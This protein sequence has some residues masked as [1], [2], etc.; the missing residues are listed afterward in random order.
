MHDVD[1][2]RR[3]LGLSSPWTVARVDLDKKEQKVDVWLEHEE[4]AHWSCPECGKR[5]SI[6]DHSEEREWRHLDTMQFQTWV[7]AK[8]PRVEC[9]DHGVK[10][11]EPTWAEP[12]SRY[13]SDFERFAIDVIQETDTRG[14]GKILKLAWDAV[15]GIEKRAVARGLLARPPLV[16]KRMGVDEKAVGHGQQYMTLVYNL[17]TSTVEWVGEGRKKDTL[18]AF[19]QTLTLEQRTGIEATG[20]DMWDPFIASILE[21]VPDAAGKMVFD[22]FHIAKH[23]NEGVDKV[24]K[25]ENRALWK[26]GDPTLKGSKY[27]WLY[28]GENLPEKHRDRFAALRALHLK[29]GR[30]YA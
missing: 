21:H 2:Y 3:L 1:L 8:L 29:T 20:L 16:L 14:A 25:S 17:E 5:F 28:R 4:G 23:A 19:F 27:L 12:G 26:E 6:Y 10:Q 30:A 13:T 18:D 15:W 24:R 7:H 9:P 11:V 22:R